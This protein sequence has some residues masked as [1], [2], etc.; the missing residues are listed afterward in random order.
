[1]AN[2]LDEGI[3]R[4]FLRRAAVAELRAQ[5]DHDAG[6]LLPEELL[7]RGPIVVASPLCHPAPGCD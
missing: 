2:R 6:I 1:M 5:H 7:D 3:L 4:A